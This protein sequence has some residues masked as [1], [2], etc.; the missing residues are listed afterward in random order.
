MR[1]P[2]LAQLLLQHD[3]RSS[4]SHGSDVGFVAGF[5]EDTARTSQIRRFSMHARATPATTLHRDAATLDF[6]RFR[7]DS[8]PK[9]C[10]KRS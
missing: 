10:K 9:Y 6:S 3:E 5:F 8:P 1:H 2:N 4:L 7:A